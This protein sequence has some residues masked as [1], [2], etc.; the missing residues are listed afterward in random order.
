MDGD[1]VRIDRGDF[2]VAQARQLKGRQAGTAAGVENSLV[3]SLGNPLEQLLVDIEMP[4]MSVLARMERRGVRIDTDYLRELSTEFATDLARLEGE[5]F[6]IAGGPFNINSPK[7]LGEVLFDKLELPVGGKT[8]INS[9][10][11]KN[12]IGAFH[13]PR[14]VIADPGVLKTL[15]IRELRAGAYEVLKC[16]VLGDRDLFAADAELRDLMGTRRRSSGCPRP[17]TRR[18]A[19]GGPG[20]R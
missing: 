12:L 15:P 11:G 7:Q 10:H 20:R 9:A 4:L 8:A 2:A 14:A 5:I 6:A 3:C 18:V 13:Q 19:L 16:A 1:G 17:I